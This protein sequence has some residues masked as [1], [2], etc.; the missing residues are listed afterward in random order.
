MALAYSIHDQAGIYFITCTVNQWAAVFS[1]KE[2]VK[3]I[4]ESLK[5][6]QQEKGLEIFAYVIMTIHMHL[7]IRSKTEKLSDII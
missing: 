3:I 5:F 6:C 1:R 4:I 2:Y 7:S